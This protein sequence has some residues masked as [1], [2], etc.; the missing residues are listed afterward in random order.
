[1]PSVK[2]QCC[3][4]ITG[5]HTHSGGKNVLHYGH[6]YSIDVDLTT[7]YTQHLNTMHDMLNTYSQSIN[8]YSI[9]R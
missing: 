9:L 3:G 5:L 8:G 2:S 6:L 4:C 7:A 1:M